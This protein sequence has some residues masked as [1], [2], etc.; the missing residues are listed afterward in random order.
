MEIVAS[1]RWVLGLLWSIRGS[2]TLGDVKLGNLVIEGECYT[3]EEPLGAS[4]T[5]RPIK[6]AGICRLRDGTVSPYSFNI[7]PIER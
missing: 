5:Q 4:I 1:E 6:D 7:R 3:S 2:R